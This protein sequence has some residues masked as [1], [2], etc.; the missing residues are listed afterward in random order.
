MCT[1]VILYRPGHDWPV[2][3]AANRDEMLD[4]AWSDPARHWPD[5]PEVVA[6]RDE[7]AGG[8]WLGVNDHGVAAGILN[9]VG[10]LGPSEDMRTRG[11]LVLDALDHSDAAAAAEALSSLDGSAYRSFNLVLADNSGAF[12]L[13]HDGAA[14]IHCEVIP[15]GYSMFTAHDR[16]SPDSPRVRRHLPRFESAPPPA[17]ERHDWQS[18]EKLLASKEKDENSDSAEG[19]ICVVTDLGFGTVNASLIALPAASSPLRRPVWRFAAGP[20]SDFSFS[21]IE[22]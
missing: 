1:L 11:E 18:W 22:V 15:P 6:G 4:R 9:R 2:L 10:S 13:R 8:S 14:A 21:I 7:L 3:I 17:P 16:N 19:A 5:R 12:W 20:P